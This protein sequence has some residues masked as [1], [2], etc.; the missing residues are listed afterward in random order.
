[1]LLVLIFRN[2]V[3]TFQSVKR[4][5][6][7]FFEM[8]NVHQNHYYE[9]ARRQI[10]QFHREREQ[11]R[12]RENM[13]REQQRF[14]RLQR[15]LEIVSEKNLSNANRIFQARLRMEFARMELEAHERRFRELTGSNENW[16]ELDPETARQ[17]DEFMARNYPNGR[18]NTEN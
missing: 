11:Q 10:E 5:S 15:E 8:A 2:S 3:F 7:S 14:D 12:E 17:W 9:K 18:A 16:R 6:T 4:E 1:M 13:E